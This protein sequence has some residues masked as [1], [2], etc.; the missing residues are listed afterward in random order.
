MA[1]V[2][3]EYDGEVQ[4]LPNISI[5]YLLQEPVRDPEWTVRQ[6]V[7]AALGDVMHPGKI[8]AC[9][10]YPYIFFCCHASSLAC[11]RL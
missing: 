3:K 7:E 6:E 1:G 11:M 5:G 2:D 9:S 10:A 8:G 4:H